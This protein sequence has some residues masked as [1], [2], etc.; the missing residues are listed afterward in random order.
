VQ[1]VDYLTYN[2]RF[3]AYGHLPIVISAS[4]L[5]ADNVKFLKVQI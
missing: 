2:Y 3:C 5:S 1:Y 4:H